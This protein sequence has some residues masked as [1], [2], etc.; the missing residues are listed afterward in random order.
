MPEPERRAA[1]E[2]SQNRLN[3]AGMGVR[4]VDSRESGVV[5]DG[6]DGLY[7]LIRDGFSGPD[8]VKAYCDQYKLIAPNCHVVTS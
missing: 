5:A 4:L 6:T 1:A 3:S 8:A 2:E 7:V